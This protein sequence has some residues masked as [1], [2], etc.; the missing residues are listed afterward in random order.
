MVKNKYLEYNKHFNKSFFVNNLSKGGNKSDYTYNLIQILLN[1]PNLIF[2]HK[3]NTINQT[4][5]KT[6]LDINDFKLYPII[7]AHTEDKGI[8][9]GVRG[10]GYCSIWAVLIGWSL[11]EKD[12][13]FIN[14]DYISSD[15]K[16]PKNLD[17]IKKILIDQGEKFLNKLEEKNLFKIEIN[18]NLVL[19]KWEIE[20]MI[21]LLKEK[22]CDTI[23]GIA[24]IKILALLLE[25][26]ILIY[27]NVEKK[28]D[29]INSNVFETIRIT[30]NGKHYNVHY[31]KKDYNNENLEKLKSSYWWIE[32]FKTFESNNIIPTFNN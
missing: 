31:N 20:L 24:H 13:L 23:N 25:V 21:Y 6:Y 7:Y 9:S 22:T 17:D 19:E 8:I 16:E 4:N 28:I 11:L 10:N 14:T 29:E 1:T 30:T 15:N 32:Q 26:H 2:L 3:L 27:D 12:K 5:K 18:Q